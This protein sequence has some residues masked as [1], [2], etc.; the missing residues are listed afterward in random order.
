MGAPGDRIAHLGV[1]KAFEE[2]EVR[3]ELYDVRGRRVGVLAESIYPAGRH[4]V[5][6]N[7]CDGRGVRVASGMYYARMTVDGRSLVRRLTVL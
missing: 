6:W 5:G 1:L 4:E 2:A 7:G 3:I